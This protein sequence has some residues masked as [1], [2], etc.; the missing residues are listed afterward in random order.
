MLESLTGFVV[1]GLAIARRLR[2]RTDRSARRART[3]RAE[4]PDVLRALA[5]PPVRRARAGGRADPVLGAAARVGDRCGG[6]SS[7]STSSV[8][9]FVWRRSVGETVDRGTVGRTGELEQHRHPALALSARQCRRIP[10]ARDPVAA[11]GLHADLDG[12]A[13]GG[14]GRSGVVLACRRARLCRIRS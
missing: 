1:V 9:R 13:R 5:V 3:T 8:S 7:P 4:P 10:G 11:A 12:G 6:S 14:H 2:P